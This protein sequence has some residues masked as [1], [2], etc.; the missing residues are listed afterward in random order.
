MPSPSEPISPEIYGAYLKGLRLVSIHLVE[1]HLERR[2]EA[3]NV[4]ISGQ[5]A[6]PT[7]EFCDGMYRI[8]QR[9]KLSAE[10]GETP[11]FDA[12]FVHELAYA[13][14]QA[15]PPGFLEQFER[16]NLSILVFPYERELVASIT[17]R[18]GF[19]PVMLEHLIVPPH[20]RP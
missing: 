16:L 1:L 5:S 10:A 17:M 18:M 14:E 8:R 13:A 3:A 20:L 7:A 11:I 15:P 9:R 4:A 12:E 19:A 2:G 6:E